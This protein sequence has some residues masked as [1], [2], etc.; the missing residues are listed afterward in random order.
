VKLRRAA[1]ASLALGTFAVA[2]ATPSFAGGAC[3]AAADRAQDL[4][5]AGKLRAAR[6]ELLVCTQQTCNAVVRADCEKWLRE[7][8]AEAPSVVVHAVDARGNAVRDVQATVD[9]TAVADGAALTVD[10]GSHLVRVTTRT[11]ES[12]ERRVVIALGERARKIEVRFEAVLDEDGTKARP[13]RASDEESPARANATTTAEEP[14]SRSLVVPIVLASIGVAGLGTFA[15][16]QI[17]GHSGYS[18]LE[19]GCARSRSCSDA[20]I[21]PVRSQFIGSTIALGVSIAAITAAVLVYFLD[22]P[23]SSSPSRVGGGKHDFRIGGPS[24]AR[25]SQ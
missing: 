20:Q 12:A 3:V 6:A 9:D 8:D 13:P 5:S 18:D 22:K 4:R 17:A 1:I 10:P 16:L 2:L 25:T 21:D 23:S 24:V 19:A 7:I 14:K 15:G 11:G